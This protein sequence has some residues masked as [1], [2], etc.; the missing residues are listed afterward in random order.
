MSYRDRMTGRYSKGHKFITTVALVLI[1]LTVG[2]FIADRMGLNTVSA[3]NEAVVPVAYAGENMEARVD[4]LKE[5]LLDEM[6]ACENPTHI[7]VWY[8]DNSAGSLPKKDK[9]SYGDLAYK[10]STLQ[11][12]YKTLKGQ[13]LTDKE[14]ALFALDADK[15]RPFTMD[16]W[17]NIKG[18]IN[19][20]SCATDGMK[21]TV[22]DIRFL[23]Q[24]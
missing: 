15:I 8:D 22:E 3:V 21:R 24:N 12:F 11:H 18:S 7:P 2:A 16:V 17:L 4:A 13:A 1:I 6:V 9:V 10:L 20:W 23:T 5:K 19:H 14:A